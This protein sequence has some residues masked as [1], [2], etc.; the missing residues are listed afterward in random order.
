MLAKHHTHKIKI[1][2]KNI[3]KYLRLFPQSKV[4]MSEWQP[5]LVM[6]LAYL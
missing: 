6:H 5:G 2:V 1:K 4:V 3:F